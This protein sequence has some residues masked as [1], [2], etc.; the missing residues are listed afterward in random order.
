MDSKIK[1]IVDYGREICL[2]N[3]L[4][5]TRLKED[6]KQKTDLSG[7]E[8]IDKEVLPIYENIYFSLEEEQLKSMIADDSE[9]LEKIK[10]NLEKILENS[11]L[12]KNFILEQLSKRKELIGKSGAEVVKKFNT[13][14]LKEYKKERAD[15]LSKINL[16][17]DE[18]EKLNL[19]LSNA[20][21][22]KEQMEIIEKIQPIREK[23][24][25]LEKKINM[26]QEEVK[27]CEEILN[28]KWPYEIYGTRE[29]KEFLDVFLKV[30]DNIDI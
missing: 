12:S 27:K 3:L 20:I 5:I 25:E 30:Y 2:Q 9:L 16:V 29:E 6:L 10:N 22:E 23:Y 21:Q 8:K 28:K 24:R 13:Y 7:I 1:E 17:L 26:F 19:D 14:K 18:E 15:L 11:N 4:L